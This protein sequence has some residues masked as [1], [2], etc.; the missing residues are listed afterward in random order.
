MR[1]TIALKLCTKIKFGRFMSNKKGP[2][3]SRTDTQELSG[4]KLRVPSALPMSG[5]FLVSCF[6]FVGVE[7]P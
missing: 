2:R 3:K 6:Y 4:P 1:R 5:D 7:G